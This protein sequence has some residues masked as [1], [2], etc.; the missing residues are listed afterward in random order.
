MLHNDLILRCTLP[1]DQ[2]TQFR[3]KER[4][5]EQKEIAAPEINPLPP[6]PIDMDYAAFREKLLSDTDRK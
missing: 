5:D 1:E 6:T 3:Q 2:A 4:D